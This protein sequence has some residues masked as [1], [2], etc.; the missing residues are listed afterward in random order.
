MC[1]SSFQLLKMFKQT[2]NLG[3]RQKGRVEGLELN[4]LMKTPESQLTA[5]QLSTKKTCT[6]QKRYP[7]PRDKW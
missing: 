5:E 3:R 1:G 4:P 2:F 7:T 6:Y